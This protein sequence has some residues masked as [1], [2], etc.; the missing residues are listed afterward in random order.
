VEVQA[1]VAKILREKVVHF[2]ESP[3]S[4]FLNKIDP[5]KIEEISNDISRQLAIIL[6]KPTTAQTVT[7]I[8]KET[9]NTQM[10]KPLAVT[11]TELF[12]SHGIAKGR[13]WAAGEITTFFRSSATKQVLHHLI[14]ELIEKKLLAKPVGPLADLIPKKIQESFADYL[15][16]QISELLVREI[17]GLVD[18]LNIRSMVS[19]K[20]DSLDLLRLERLLM[21]IMEEQFKYINLFGALLGFLIGL[22]NLAVLTL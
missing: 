6:A 7:A 1:K 2:M 18:S 4:T 8:L 3:C 12:G 13:Q 19:R 5:A 10:D 21:G 11:M 20:V 9:I 16:T 14:V 15:L 17:P 22:L